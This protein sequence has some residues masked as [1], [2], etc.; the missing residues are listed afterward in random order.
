MK[1]ALLHDAV[2]LL[3]IEGHLCQWHYISCQAL[4]CA[5]MQFSQLDYPR[6]KQSGAVVEEMIPFPDPGKGILGYSVRNC[7]FVFNWLFG[8]SQWEH[9]TP[10]LSTWLTWALRYL[11][12]LF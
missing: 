11:D 2:S 3:T 8:I 7:V 10:V 1:P 6:D 4:Q 5:C 9:H 12:F